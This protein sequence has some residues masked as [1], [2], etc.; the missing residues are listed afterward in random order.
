[1]SLS[2]ENKKARRYIRSLVEQADWMG[3]VAC[4][5]IKVVF[6]PP[7]KMEDCFATTELKGKGNKKYI[8]IAFDEEYLNSS[9]GRDLCRVN[10]VHELAHAFTWV[11][12]LEVE[13]SRTSKYG[14]HG[15]D[16]GIVYAQLWTDLIEGR[17][18]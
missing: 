8:E 10:M 9:H 14:V 6:L 16:F 18:D 17:D 7:E 15:P 3:H 1:M 5:P 2:K 4:H 11:S 13:E 12:D